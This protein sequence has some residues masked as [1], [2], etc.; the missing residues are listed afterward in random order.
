MNNK[1]SINK[2]GENKEEV[3]GGWFEEGLSTAPSTSGSELHGP[4]TPTSSFVMVARHWSVPADQKNKVV[5]ALRG[6]CSQ[7]VSNF[8]GQQNKAS[9]AVSALEQMHFD[10]F[11]NS[12]R[13]C[14]VSQACAEQALCLHRS[15]G[16]PPGYC[17]SNML[18]CN[19]HNYHKTSSTFQKKISCPPNRVPL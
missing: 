18:N 19:N 2:N 13:C 3:V 12:S 9:A 10:V 5:T 1:N 17:L 15:T 4:L 6:C 8:I 14:S 7:I 16:Q 11:L